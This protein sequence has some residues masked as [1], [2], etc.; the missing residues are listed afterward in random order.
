MQL[1]CN[2]KNLR[3]S[4]SVSSFN[5]L[6]VALSHYILFAC[7]ENLFLC[8]FIFSYI[9]V[10]LD[11]YCFLY[12][13]VLF[14]WFWFGLFVFNNNRFSALIMVLPLHVCDFLHN[15]YFYIS[16]KKGIRT[17]AIKNILKIFWSNKIHWCF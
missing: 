5:A 3:L 10:N 12:L 13:T 6:V 4:R 7:V 2:E 11:K 1:V 15:W 16:V 8:C 17:T 9:S 14:L